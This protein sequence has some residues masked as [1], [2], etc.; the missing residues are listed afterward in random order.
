MAEDP[1][2]EHVATA[3]QRHSLQRGRD[4]MGLD[5]SDELLDKLAPIFAWT[6]RAQ[7]VIAVEAVL[8]YFGRPEVIECRMKAWREAEVGSHYAERLRV[9]DAAAR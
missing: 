1:L 4:S 6:S 5:E 9:A 8:E 2:V 3:L 7:A